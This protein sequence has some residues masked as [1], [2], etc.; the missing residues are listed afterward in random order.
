MQYW[1]MTLTDSWHFVQVDDK[2]S[3]RRGVT[4]EYHKDRSWDL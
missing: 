1:G 2:T 4:L 3:D